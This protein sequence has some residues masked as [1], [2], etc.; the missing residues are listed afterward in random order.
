MAQMIGYQDGLDWLIGFLKKFPLVK[1]RPVGD[2]PA[3]LEQ[4]YGLEKLERT[5]RI[6]KDDHD[7]TIAP[8]PP[9]DPPDPPDPPK[10]PT[11]PR[12]APM[13]HYAA[14]GAD[15]RFCVHGQPGVTRLSPDEYVDEGG[16]RYT[17]NGLCHGG[18][19]GTFVAILKPANSMDGKEP[20]DGYTKDG[21]TFPPWPP[22]SY[23]I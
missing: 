16:Y 11:K 7:S 2:R 12:L 22:E 8:S 4:W 10:P 18:R 1:Y 20:C 3:S 19:T 23:E 13:T 5:L 9:P 6:L 17:E 14:P 21:R 15:A